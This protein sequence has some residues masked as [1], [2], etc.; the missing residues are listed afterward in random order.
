MNYT[1]QLKEEL[2]RRNWDDRAEIVGQRNRDKV[3]AAL[4][5]LTRTNDAK[6]VRYALSALPKKEIF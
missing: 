6:I 5:C 2:M 3:C 1:S 4:E